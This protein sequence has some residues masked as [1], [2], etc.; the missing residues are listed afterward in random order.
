VIPKKKDKQVWCIEP[1][2]LLFELCSKYDS[3]IVIVEFSSC[4]E[5]DVDDHAGLC[6]LC[7]RTRIRTLRNQLLPRNQMCE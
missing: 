6:C 3:H 5:K 1:L 2:E 7:G 4:G